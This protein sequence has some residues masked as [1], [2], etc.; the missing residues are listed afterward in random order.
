[1][2]NYEFHAAKIMGKY[3]LIVNCTNYMLYKENSSNYEGPN[4]MYS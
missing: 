3:K 1:M 4:N 2:E